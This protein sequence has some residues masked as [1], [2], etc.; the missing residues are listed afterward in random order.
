MR[1]SDDGP[2]VH[3]AHVSLGRREDVNTDGLARRLVAAMRERHGKGGITC[4]RECVERARDEAMSCPGCTICRE[5]EDARR[6]LDLAS[7]TRRR[8]ERE[9]DEAEEEEA[10]AA[11]RAARAEDAQTKHIEDERRQPRLFR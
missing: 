7:D 9:L 4:C 11:S 3:F 1:R 6:A 5:A 8:A 2:I 10:S